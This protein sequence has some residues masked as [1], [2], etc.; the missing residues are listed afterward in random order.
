MLAATAGCATL[1]YAA[2][3][4][5]RDSPSRFYLP[6]AATLCAVAATLPS[7]IRIGGARRAA[8]VVGAIALLWHSTERLF[9]LKDRQVA[10]TPLAVEQW[11]GAIL[12]EGFIALTQEAARLSE[13]GRL[14]VLFDARAELFPRDACV[15]SVW[16]MPEWEVH[17]RAAARWPV[18]E[19]RVARLEQA[20]AQ[21]HIKALFVNEFEF[22]RALDFYSQDVLPGRHRGIAGA[23]SASFEAELAASPFVRIAILADDETALLAAF[24]RE[25]RSDA[26]S[27]IAAGTSAEIWLAPVRATGVRLSDGI[28]GVR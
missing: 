3:L 13:G 9:L 21:M 11:R 4:L 1:G 2:L 8:I 18:E 26:V 27:A 28:D 20:L 5:V 19:E 10:A 14:A 12:G 16:D 17:L 22:G 6:Q 24:L 15:S 7:A 25:K 23:R